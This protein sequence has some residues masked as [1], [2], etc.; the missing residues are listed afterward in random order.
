MYHVTQGTKAHYF[1]LHL[2]FPVRGKY[3]FRHFSQKRS[4]RDPAPS[5][6]LQ[7]PKLLGLSFLALDSLG[8]VWK[9][10]SPLRFFLHLMSTHAAIRGLIGLRL[11]ARVQGHLTAMPM[12]VRGIVTEADEQLP[13]NEDLGDVGRTFGI[14]T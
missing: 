12:R 14:E 4:S 1:D 9:S 6:T 2:G 7:G 5:T 11:C 3:S 8:L 13:P 10:L